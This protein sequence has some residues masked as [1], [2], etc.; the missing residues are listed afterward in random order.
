MHITYKSTQANLIL[1]FVERRYHNPQGNKFL[2]SAIVLRNHIIRWESINRT[3]IGHGNRR[4]LLSNGPFSWN[5]LPLHLH[6]IVLMFGNLRSKIC[7]NLFPDT[8][9][10]VLF[11][12]EGLLNVLNIILISLDTMS[13]G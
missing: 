5:S 2:S 8:A 9:I 10:L 4:V 13:H 11:S 1:R 3:A 7:L 6:K 12:H